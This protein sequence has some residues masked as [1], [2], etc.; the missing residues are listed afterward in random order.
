MPRRVV[1]VNHDTSVVEIESTY[2]RY[3][4]DHTDA[5]SR[6]GLLDIAAAPATGNIVPIA[7]RTK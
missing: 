3:I 5:V 1:A 7:A 4:T 2:S 6:A